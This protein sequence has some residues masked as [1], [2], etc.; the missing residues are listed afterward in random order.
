[1]DF[2]NEIWSR[3]IMTKYRAFFIDL[4]ES[5]QGKFIKISEKSNKGRSTIMMDSEDLP[6]FIETL[7]ELEK[8]L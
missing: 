6:E 3:K 8:Q 4:K 7:Q 2:N 5:A 1:M